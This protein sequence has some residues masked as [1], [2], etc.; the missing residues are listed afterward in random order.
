MEDH[1]HKR[2]EKYN[3]RRLSSSDKWV[4]V[5]QIREDYP[6]RISE[7]RLSKYLGNLV[8]LPGI[9]NDRDELQ[10]CTERIRM[11]KYLREKLLPPHSMHCSN[12]SGRIYVEKTL[13]Q[14]ILNHYHLQRTR[15]K[16]W[17]DMY[18]SEGLDNWQMDN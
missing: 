14:C 1:I 5:K 15:E 11:Q 13:E 7:C 2:M 10:A 12:F 8:D 4:P 3:P 16:A 17:W 9:S 18:S 6:P